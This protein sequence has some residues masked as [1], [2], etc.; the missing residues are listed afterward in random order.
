[1]ENLGFNKEIIF[2]ELLY[3]F[4]REKAFVKKIKE[5]YNLKRNSNVKEINFFSETPF[6]KL[7]FDYIIG[8]PPYSAE[9]REE[10]LRYIKENPEI[11]PINPRESSV[12]FICKAIHLLKPGGKLFFVLPATLLRIKKYLPI[13]DFLKDKV[14]INLLV[15]LGRKFEGVGYETV[16]VGFTKKKSKP[17]KNVKLITKVKN[18]EKKDYAVNYLKYKEFSEREIFPLYLNNKL[19]KLTTQIEK[20][21][22][23]LNQIAEMPRGLEVNITNKKKVIRQKKKNTEQILC[24]RNIKKY[25][26]KSEE[27]QY[28]I[29]SD[30]VKNNN[31]KNK[32]ILV[33]NLAYKI[34]AALDDKGFI[35]NNTVNNVFLKKDEYYYEYILAVLNSWLMIFYLQNV[36]TNKA[37]LNIHLDKPY[38][39]KIPIK[40]ISKRK[41]V[42]VV[43]LVT[44]LIKNIKNKNI[45]NKTRKKIEDCVF[46]IYGINPNID[47][48]PYI[49]TGKVNI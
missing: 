46:Q 48:T 8:N 35:T 6:D 16:I 24:G 45:T 47:L 1:M 26:I 27:P 11:F 22:V 2:N 29:H 7:K 18:L 40:K 42:K 25:Y 34:V 41:Q 14:Y 36:I 12:L 3:C 38:L 33:Q 17:P 43:K 32:K 15:N 21:T 30:Y 37:R 4:D 28:F 39:G 13:R 31:L 49:I 23:R 5:K 10:E 44:D 20:D 9:I 19:I